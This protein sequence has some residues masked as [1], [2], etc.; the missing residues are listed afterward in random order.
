MSRVISRGTCHLCGGQYAKSGMTRHLAACLE[1]EAAAAKP[2]A[3][4][5]RRAPLLQLAIEGRD[6]PMYWL[7]LLA[8][9][10]ATLA[11]LDRL[12]RDTWLECCGHLSA[13]EIENVRYMPAGYFELDKLEAEDLVQ[14]ERA[15]DL[16]D[17]RVITPD[18]AVHEISAARIQGMLDAM[19][20][21]E[22]L[23]VVDMPEERSMEVALGDV[24]RPGLRFTHEYDFGTTTELMLRVVAEREGIVSRKE[25]LRVIARN[26]P[27]AIACQ[28]CAQ[29]AT[30]VCA[31]CIWNGEGALCKRHARGHPCGREMLLPIVNSPRTGMCA[32][33]GQER[34]WI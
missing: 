34:S 7:H 6:L 11:D 25:P 21:L 23:G 32:Y 10:A 29:P 12:L 13:F 15:A 19:R 3:R 22:A 8:P 33:T 26:D 18:G 4:G 2:P 24:L 14:N 17:L 30:L 16:P 1:R 20:G 31:E 27:P 5:S 9:A 28:V